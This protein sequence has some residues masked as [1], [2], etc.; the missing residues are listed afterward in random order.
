MKSKNEEAIII[1]VVVVQADDG[2]S[3]T[4]PC[5]KQ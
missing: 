2:D 5:E 3:L 1:I 4:W